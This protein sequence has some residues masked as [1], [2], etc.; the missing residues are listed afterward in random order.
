MA[1]AMLDLAALETVLVACGAGMLWVAY[2]LFRS[3]ERMHEELA[4]MRVAMR[5]TEQ[6]IHDKTDA[7]LADLEDIVN[8]NNREA[9]AHR[10]AVLMRLAEIPTRREF[11]EFKAE[12][13]ATLAGAKK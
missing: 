12:I 7:K 13:I 5:E 3:T 2:Y 6:R 1:N 4:D 8:I 10:E 11:G 9:Q